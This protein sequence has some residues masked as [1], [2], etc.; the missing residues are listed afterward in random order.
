MSRSSS[1]QSPVMTLRMIFCTLE[2]FR[3]ECGPHNLNTRRELKS[4]P[5]VSEKA[6]VKRASAF[7]VR[8]QV[9]ATTCVSLGLS[10]RCLRFAGNRD[11][12]DSGR[13]VPVPLSRIDLPTRSP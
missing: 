13:I 1:P 5:R 2:T 6:E 3:S 8:S 11:W 7:F 9:H 12:L 10:Q 4:D